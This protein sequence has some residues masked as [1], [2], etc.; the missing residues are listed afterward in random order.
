MTTLLVGLIF[1]AHAVYESDWF[2]EQV[3]IYRAREKRRSI[4]RGE[5][6][7][8]YRLESLDRLSCDV[9]RGVR[10]RETPYFPWYGWILALVLLCVDLAG[11]FCLWRVLAVRPALVR[12]GARPKAA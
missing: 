3:L 2:N 4:E 10:E 6:C 5:N 7:E 1:I 12:H 9:W 11:C 8:Q